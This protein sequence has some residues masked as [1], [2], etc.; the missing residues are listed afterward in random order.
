MIR[1]QPSE[2]D[3]DL[4]AFH[5]E[6]LLAGERR[7]VE[8]AVLRKRCARERRC[9]DDERKEYLHARSTLRLLRRT[10][11]YQQGAPRNSAS[12]DLSVALRWPES[13]GEG[14][15]TVLFA[16]DEVLVRLSVA[17]GLRNEGLE[18]LEAAD[19]EEAISILK[20]LQ[21]EVVI[22]DLN[23]RTPAEGLAVANYVRAHC[24]GTALVLAPR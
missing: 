23:M 24:P 14:T 9:Q 7:K 22:G 13:S 5:L 20:T 11:I 10:Q 19:A 2:Y 3:I 15:Q 1:L 8:L 4:L 16:E 18:V 6:Q 17:E 12:T 21:V